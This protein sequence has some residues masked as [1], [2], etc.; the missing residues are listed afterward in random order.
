[1]PPGRGCL[2]LLADVDRNDV[3]A[4]LGQPDGMAPALTPGGT[5]DERDLPVELSHVAVLLVR[6]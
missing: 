4:L 2:H 6:W 5:G 1:M 3:S